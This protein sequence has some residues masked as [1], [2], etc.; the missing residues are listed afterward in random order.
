MLAKRDQWLHP[1]VRASASHDLRATLEDTLRRIVDRHLD[2]IRKQLREAR[3]AELFELAQYSAGNLIAGDTLTAERRALLEACLQT[4]SPLAAQ[5]ACLPA[6]RAI[7]A[8]V[9]KQDGDLYS[10]VTKVHGFP[11]TNRDAKE[12]ILRLLRALS[13][14]PDLCENL[15]ELK[16]LPDPR[17]ADE[18]WRILEALLALLPAAVAELQFVFQARGQADY[19]EITFAC[20]AGARHGGR[21]HRFGARLRLSACSTCWSMSSRTPRSRN[22]ICSSD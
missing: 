12:R 8:M 1:I 7:A 10:T 2:A 19:V 15:A 11:T 5:S 20:T 14:E 21:T 9:F 6:W 17:Y 22:S 16:T 18:Q 4:S 3:L 13:L